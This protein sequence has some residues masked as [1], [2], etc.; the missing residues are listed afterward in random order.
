[1]YYRAVSVPN[2]VTPNSMTETI[3]QAVENNYEQVEKSG[4]PS[5]ESVA[6]QVENCVRAF[7]PSALSSGYAV[8][9]CVNESI[10]GTQAAAMKTP[11]SPPRKVEAQKAFAAPWMPAD[12]DC[13]QASPGTSRNQCMALTDS[14]TPFAAHAAQGME[15]TPLTYDSFMAERASNLL[16]SNGSP[17]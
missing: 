3:Q 8:S 7:P 6:F 4:R 1:M 15:A 2:G 11:A 16:M 17:F 12:L 10:L 9:L 14:H 13:G 5:N